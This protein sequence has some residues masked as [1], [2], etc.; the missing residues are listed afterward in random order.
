MH[1]GRKPSYTRFL[2]FSI[3]AK[4]DAMTVCCECE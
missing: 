4:L 1:K 2:S 3:F